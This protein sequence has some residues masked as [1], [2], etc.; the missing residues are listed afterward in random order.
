MAKSDRY[1]NAL[2]RSS[3]SRLVP[4]RLSWV[5]VLRVAAGI[6]VVTAG[7][8]AA[9]AADWAVATARQ[10]MQ[11]RM[12]IYGQYTPRTSMVHVGRIE[13]AENAP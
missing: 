4:T 9:G 10:T 2:L 3:R 11:G 7:L 12:A 5:K 6:A 13:I 8:A 1:E